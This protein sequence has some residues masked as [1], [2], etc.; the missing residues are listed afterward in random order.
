MASQP[1][2]DQDKGDTMIGLMM[3]DL[4]FKNAVNQVTLGENADQS[5]GIHSPGKL[6]IAAVVGT[7]RAYITLE[8]GNVKVKSPS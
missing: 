8:F 5:N 4:Y 7:G 1:H 3:G 2:T 6:Q